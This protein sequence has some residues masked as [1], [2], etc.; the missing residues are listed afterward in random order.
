MAEAQDVLPIAAGIRALRR[1]GRRIVTM[2]VEQG[3][4]VVEG[5]AS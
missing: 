3:Y 5:G 1:H 2:L 4:R